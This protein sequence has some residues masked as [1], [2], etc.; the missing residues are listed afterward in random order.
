[1]P[2]LSPSAGLTIFLTY[3]LF[4]LLFYMTLNSSNYQMITIFKPSIQKN[5]TNPTFVYELWQT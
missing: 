2:Q 4:L 5:L 3:T 1:M